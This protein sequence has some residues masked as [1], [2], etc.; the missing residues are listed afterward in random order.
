MGEMDGINNIPRARHSDPETSR[1]AAGRLLSAKSQARLLLDAHLEAP[2]GLTDAEAARRAGLN[3]DGICW[4]HRCSDLR[5]LGLIEWLRDDNGK[6]RKM[7][8]LHN[9]DVGV[10]VITGKGRQE[11]R[12]S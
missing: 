11:L 3:R 9:R 7:R 10:S 6:V 1:L 5:A 8:G 2:G 4:W 12:S